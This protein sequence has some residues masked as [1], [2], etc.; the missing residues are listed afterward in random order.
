MPSSKIPS[1]ARSQ[2]SLLTPRRHRTRSTRS[3]GSPA[4]SNTPSRLTA[5]IMQN[6]EPSFV[7]SPLPTRRSVL[8]DDTEVEEPQ[9]KSWWRK[10]DENS[11]DILEVLEGNKVGETYEAVEEILNVEILSQEKKNYT[12]DLPESSDSESINS[13]VMPQRKLFIQKENVP[14]KKFGQLID[15]RESLANVDKTTAHEKSVTVTTKSLFQNNKRKRV[16]PAA[17]L[18]LSPNKTT[19]D[20]TKQCIV[21]PPQNQARNIFGYRPAAKRKNMFAE[22]I[23]SESEDEISEIQPKVFEYQ[24]QFDH[25]RS[26][27]SN[28]RP[29]RETSPASS[30]TTDMELDDWKYLPS[31]TIVESHDQNLTENHAN[32]I[33][34]KEHD[35]KKQVSTQHA[36]Q[37]ND[38]D[39][40]MVCENNV[41]QKMF[42]DKETDNRQQ[43]ITPYN[44]DRGNNTSNKDQTQKEAVEVE[45]SH[46]EFQEN[47]QN[48]TNK[49][50]NAGNISNVDNSSEQADIFTPQNE[51]IVEQENENNDF[52]KPEN[53]GS[54]NNIDIEKNANNEKNTPVEE[55]DQNANT[56]EKIHHSNNTDISSEQ[57]AEVIASNEEEQMNS[58]G[59]ET[60]IE[61]S[62]QNAE[63]EASC[64]EEEQEETV[65][66]ECES[67][68][69]NSE[70]ALEDSTIENNDETESHERSGDQ[71]RKSD[72]DIEI[73]ENVERSELGNESNASND[74]EHLY[75]SD[76]NDDEPENSAGADINV[77]D[78]SPNTDNLD[79]NEITDRSETLEKVNLPEAIL[80][81]KKNESDLFTMQGNNTDLRKT[82]SMMLMSIRPSLLPPVESTSMTDGTRN[83]S[84]EGSGWDSH[85]TTRKTLRQTFGKDFTPRKSLRALVMEKSA[86]RQT[87]LVDAKEISKMPQA[88][89]TEIPEFNDDYHEA[90]ES[91]EPT[92]HEIS[93]NTRQATL[94]IYLQKIK[95]SNMEK[96]MRIEQEVRNSLK[97]MKQCKQNVNN[98]K[99]P[100]KPLFARHSTKPVQNKNKVREMKSSMPLGDLPPELLEDMK[101]K[102]PKRYQPKNASWTTKRLYKYLEDK[103][104]PKYDY[105]ARVRAEK[106][107][108]TIYHFT[109]EVKK[110]E[111]APNDAVDVLKH[112]MARLDIV[113]THFDFY[114]FF[115]DFMPREIR[116]KVVPDIVN[117][118]TIPRNGVFSGILSGHTVHA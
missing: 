106:L 84:A 61:E 87:A 29:I 34:L 18:N 72:E 66:E 93:K 104:E 109:K 78:N 91:I 42:Q 82:K 103:L 64:A 40:E 113:K 28:S 77:N 46:N 115:H 98:F 90:E 79:N 110:H 56:E 4:R 32:T 89:S 62:D 7:L 23:V 14:K 5:I 70:R 118:I 16:F 43:G 1:P 111:V 105:K 37:P 55:V 63:S 57:N 68:E 35:P 21:D 97:A 6:K 51:E 15:N 47:Q 8:N 117:K 10:L 75:L 49:Q 45:H 36:Q 24:K 102:P 12:S 50:K 96:N 67:E 60:G 112:E 11:R 71:I 19:V 25:R 41:D 52:R 30:I 9:R 73:D 114:Q 108:E 107:V 44:N 81:D 85:R 99:V 76:D 92:N 22:F 26:R 31:S 80:H 88:N 95:K 3:V 59:N 94:E 101:Y 116:V 38:E 69:N 33:V 53:I 48:I 54:Q 65:N 17:A 39:H 27:V 2:G 86:K 74:D 20:K 13:I 100:G 58:H 83:S